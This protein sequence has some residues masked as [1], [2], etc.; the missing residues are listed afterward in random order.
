MTSNA[1]EFTLREAA[2]NEKNPGLM[3]NLLLNT[4]L[5]PDSIASVSWSG[6]SGHHRLD[7]GSGVNTPGHFDAL[8]GVSSGN[9]RQFAL[10]DRNRNQLNASFSHHLS[11]HELKVGTEIE[12]SR[13]GDHYSVP[14][15]VFYSDNEG[16]VTDRSTGKPDYY[17]L[18]TIGG[19]YNARGTNERL[20]V[21][22]QDSWH[23]TPNI[24]FNPG[25]R[26]DR[27]R[28]KVTGATVFN[29]NGI[30]PRLGVAWDLRGDG[31]TVVKAHVGRYYEALYAAF[32]YYM[33]P[34]A[35]EPM[36]TKRTFNTSHFTETLTNIPGQQYAMDPNIKQPYLDQVVAGFDQQLGRGLRLSASLVYRRNKNLIETVSRDGIFVP[37]N[38]QIPGSGQHVT[39]YD[40]LNPNTDVLLYTNPKGLKRSYEALIVSA[41]RPLTDKWLFS[42]SYVF[43]RARGNI[44][45]LGFDETG[46]GANTPFFDGH[47]LDTPNSLVNAEGRLTH[48]QTHQIKLQGTRLFPRR[49]QALSWDYIYHSG[50]TW[51]PRTTCLLVNGACHD[52]PQGPVTYFAEPRGSRRMKARSE[53]DLGWEWEPHFWGAHGFH[54][55][56]DMF[57]VMN[58]E[59]GTTVETLVGTEAF[60]QP[61]TANFARHLRLGFRFEW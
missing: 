12:H 38:G 58:Q 27:N 48:D 26:I 42:G 13:V 59:R 1:D 17:T 16:P 18:T 60:G 43:S 57:N 50:D 10:I 33:A 39:L 31:R 34:G 37:V 44:D 36:I 53:L 46:V 23:I 9:A 3:G 61:A 40:Y 32:Y 47:F 28:G 6:Y 55:N 21:Y 30:A 4:A 20:S 35:F 52:F 41:T 51:T 7:A 29:T 11:R 54:L 5:S 56:I 25:L 45:N 24:T 15:G 14:G 49:H 19:G 22:A 8:S 2:N